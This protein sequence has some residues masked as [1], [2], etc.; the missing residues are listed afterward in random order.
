MGLLDRDKRIY[1]YGLI[2]CLVLLVLPSFSS[3]FRFIAIPTALLI[4]INIR[5]LK[6]PI[7]PY[8]RIFS[9]VSENGIIWKKEKGIR[10]DTKRKVDHAGGIYYPQVIKVPNGFRMYYRGGDNF[11]DDIF[12]SFSKDGLS[13]DADTELSIDLR[14]QGFKS[15]V[16]CFILTGDSFQRMYLS[17]DK[18]TGYQ[19]YSAES[20]DYL[21]WTIEEGI[22]I[23]N[24]T[25]LDES[26]ARDPALI[27][28][29]QG[30]RM[31]YLGGDGVC[32]RILSAF[33]DDGLNWQK[34]GICIEPQGQEHPECIKSPFVY[35]HQG[36][37]RMYFTGGSRY[38]EIYTRI[39][40]AKSNDGLNW[41][42]K[43]NIGIRYGGFNDY[44]E[45]L[46]P[47]VLA[48]ENGF[49]RMYYSGLGIHLLAPLT[50]LRYKR[51]R[52]KAV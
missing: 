2:I 5:F 18:G 14:R 7:F 12:T 1:Y 31:Y 8:D 30:L 10:I 9:A 13:W 36:H 33:S 20:N 26:F 42:R 27:E 28:T 48:E 43:E 50:C 17:G 49:S 11:L 47:C 38:P 37:F 25:S 19:I 51:R 45:I 6:I 32:N 22:R 24:D 44:F 29:E 4:A 23:A 15:V 35:R 21:H 16:S 3:I 39:L 34:E 52:L 46:T 40:G 41:R